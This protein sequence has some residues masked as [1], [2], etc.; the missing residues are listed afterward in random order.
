MVTWVIF[1]AR[2]S[3]TTK[4]TFVALS[5]RGS[6]LIVALSWFTL[7]YCTTK[8]SVTGKIVTLEQYKQRESQ[9]NVLSGEDIRATYRWRSEQKSCDYLFRS[10]IETEFLAP[11]NGNAPVTAAPTPSDEFHYLAIRTFSNRR[12]C[13]IVSQYATHN[14][15]PDAVAL[16]NCYLSA[17]SRARSWAATSLPK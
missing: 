2:D 13:K 9:A 17:L 1:R 11:R 16:L 8:A 4:E 15:L 14:Q 5:W 12:G 6:D 7:R 3:R 10:C